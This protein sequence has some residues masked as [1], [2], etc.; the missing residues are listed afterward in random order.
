MIHQQNKLKTAVF[1]LF[2]S[3]V[4]C[5][6]SLHHLHSPYHFESRIIF[7]L[8]KL[9]VRAKFRYHNAMGQGKKYF[10]F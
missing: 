9:A 6:A 1:S 4:E 2:S 3:T 10:S 5:R 7:Q 8:L